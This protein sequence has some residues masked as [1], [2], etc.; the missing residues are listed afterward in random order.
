M[1]RIIAISVLVFSSIFTI[2][3]FANTSDIS[4]LNGIRVNDNNTGT[5]ETTRSCVGQ[6]CGNAYAKEKTP[7]KPAQVYTV[8]DCLKNADT[9]VDNKINNFI[10]SHRRIIVHDVKLS[11]A[12]VNTGSSLCITETLIYSMP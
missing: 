5:A 4:G 7:T 8:A 9:T 11:T 2:N 3:A 10:S 1:K 12:V 6:D